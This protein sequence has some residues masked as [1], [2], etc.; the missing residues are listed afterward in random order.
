M[1]LK[2]LLNMSV[3]EASEYNF[4]NECGVLDYLKLDPF[5]RYFTYKATAE[6]CQNSAYE[7]GEIFAKEAKE[8]VPHMPD[9]DGTLGTDVCELSREIYRKLWG[10]M[11]IEGEKLKRYAVCADSEFKEM[12]PDTMNSCKGILNEKVVF[13]KA[14]QMFE[15]YKAS[16]KARFSINFELELFSNPETHGRFMT[17]LKRI[18]ELEKYLLAYHTIG[19]FTLVPAYFNSYRS[20]KVNDFWDKSLWLLQNNKWSHTENG[21]KEIEWENKNFKKYVNTFFMWDYIDDKEN[22]VVF[23]EGTEML[24]DEELAKYME[25]VISKI[26]NRGIFMYTMLKII[27]I[28]SYYYKEI[29][30]N[31]FSKS[32]KIYTGYKEVIQKIKEQKCYLN[33]GDVRKLFETEQMQSLEKNNII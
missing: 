13:K 16:S 1:T 14:D 22:V 29:K 10:W 18:P 33:D 4:E 21:A 8:F 26:Y 19:N 5:S 17:E 2:D 7:H 25:N 6:G 15:K 30:D 12:G 24:S 28:N 11:D 3:K 9:C 23:S 27:E 20:G 32:D 31:I